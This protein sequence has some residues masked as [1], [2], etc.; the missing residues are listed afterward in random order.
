MLNALLIKTTRKKQTPMFL[1]PIMLKFCKGRLAYNLLVTNSLQDMRGL[2]LERN[3][4]DKKFPTEPLSRFVDARYQTKKCR[5]I[6]RT[7][8]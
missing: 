5:W 2:I 1:Q 4:I 7:E 6:F 8:V 3:Q